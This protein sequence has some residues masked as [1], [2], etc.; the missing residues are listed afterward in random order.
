MEGLPVYAGPSEGLARL[1]LGPFLKIRTPASHDPADPVPRYVDQVPGW[2]RCALIRDEKVP[3]QSAATGRKWTQSAFWLVRGT[4]GADRARR[5]WEAF[6]YEVSQ[7]RTPSWHE[8]HHGRQAQRFKLDVECYWEQLEALAGPAPSGRVLRGLV[9]DLKEHVLETIVDEFAARY[10]TGKGT[11]GGTPEVIGESDVVVYNASAPSIFEAGRPCGLGSGGAVF[12]PNSRDKISFH[13][14]VAPYAAVDAAEARVFAVAVAESL[15]NLPGDRALYGDFVDLGTFGKTTQGFRIP[16]SAK[17]DAPDRPL[18]FDRT[19]GLGSGPS[20]TDPRALVAH[21]TASAVAVLG[22]PTVNVAAH[23]SIPS[24]PDEDVKKALEVTKEFW[25]T[26]FRYR[27]ATGGI[28]SFDRKRASPCHICVDVATGTPRVHENDN[29]LMLLV[30]P[31]SAE[32][33]DRAGRGRKVTAI[34]RRAKGRSV[35][36]GSF[37]SD[38]PWGVTDHMASAEAEKAEGGSAA[39]GFSARYLEDAVSRARTS[40][41]RLSEMAEV[42][43]T[44]DILEDSIMFNRALASPGYGWGFGG[45]PN[46]DEGED[47]GEG[48]AGP[49]APLPE[50]PKDDDEL[51]ELKSPE[52]LS[53]D[54]VASRSNP[55]QAIPPTVPTS[56]ATS[57]PIWRE[58]SPALPDLQL[59]TYNDR[60][61]RPYP[62]PE[63]YPDQF[64]AGAMGTGKTKQLKNYLAAHFPD[65]A[66][67]PARVLCVTFRRSLA[68]FTTARLADLGFVLYSEVK[69][70][71]TPERHP[72][73]VIQVE[74]LGRLETMGA[75]HPDLLVL[76]EVESVIGQIGSGLAKNQRRTLGVF[77]WLVRYSRCVMCLDAH[78]GAR[79]AAVI[80]GLRYDTGMGDPRDPPPARPPPVLVHNRAQPGRGESYRLT[81]SRPTWQI[82][83]LEAVDSGRRVVVP[84]NSLAE[85]KTVYYLLCDRYGV[86]REKVGEMGA[87][88]VK[89]ESDSDGEYDEMGNPIVEELPPVTL[90][91]ERLKKIVHYTSQTSSDVRA[92][93]LSNV[94]TAWADVDVLIYTPTISAGVSFEVPEHFDEVFALFTSASCDALAAVQMLGRVRSLRH[95]RYT[96]CLLGRP[97][98][99]LLPVDDSGLIQALDRR[100]NELVGR[101]SGSVLAPTYLLQADG[102]AVPVKTPFLR[103]WLAN[104][105]VRN[106]SRNDYA[107]RLSELLIERGGDI[108]ILPN[109]EDSAE[110]RTARQLERAAR[111]GAAMDEA[112]AVSNAVEIDVVQ[113]NQLRLAV[114]AASGEM[115]GRTRLA[116]AKFTLRNLYRLALIR[117]EPN[118]VMKY[119]SFATARLFR[120]V[121]DLVSAAVST[122][123]GKA[124][125]VLMAINEP[126]LARTLAAAGGQATGEQWELALVERAASG[127]GVRALRFSLIFWAIRVLGFDDPL[128]LFRRLIRAPVGKAAIKDKSL[129]PLVAAAL[130]PRFVAA[131]SEAEWAASSI[132][133]AELQAHDVHSK[134]IDG[135]SPKV[136]KALSEAGLP[137]AGPAKLAADV[138]CHIL[139]AGVGLGLRAAPDGLRF[140]PTVKG[141]SVRYV[142]PKKVS[143]WNLVPA[144]DEIRPYIKIPDT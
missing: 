97:P 56:A 47:E 11:P 57:D 49:S 22:D 13:F 76:D 87:G 116:L 77:E 30:S 134:G 98:T 111:S 92:R 106:E 38:A 10:G 120:D 54:H 71:L 80:G 95:R 142:D 21:W 7:G 45:A 20:A 86:E 50:V 133:E 139:R 1:L 37:E 23:T 128:D 137:P 89:E 9:R 82:H 2:E 43:E 125:D 115:S 33:G 55:V 78:L 85:A 62:D 118:W 126:A 48:S 130:V 75:P 138:T 109:S 119:S 104:Q 32:I 6:D 64:I 39:D 12:I 25:S 8:L 100:Q 107:G 61:M 124:Q 3:Y 132:S 94:D 144:D 19:V 114:R 84:T 117:L 122:S 101:R 129:P 29:T 68:H 58:M 93:D 18:R 91:T 42:P 88:E 127:A 110:I 34:C 31:E 123:T 60:H 103:I 63:K 40:A 69:G 41:R 51:T 73:L 105:R 143:P 35:L 131:S 26:D 113:A 16:G 121:R 66:E 46:V 70:A 108:T 44:G 4:S 53:L 72:R 24:V 15:R 27:S 90:G 135:F 83:L 81:T 96:I 102:R 65:S 5:L 141:N 36:V 67:M 112:E 28:I 136:S 99:P 74:S 59:Q 140:A 52:V 79:S 17:R 14:L